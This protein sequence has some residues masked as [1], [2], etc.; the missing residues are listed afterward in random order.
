MGG[1]LCSPSGP[2]PP[3]GVIYLQ[4]RTKPGPFT[5]EDRARAELCAAQIASLADRLLLRNS[6][7]NDGTSAWRERLDAD[8]IIGRSP[9]VAAL[10]EDIALAAP[11]DVSVLIVGETG[12]GKTH[13]ARAIHRN[14]RRNEGPFVEL[15]CATLQ[16][17]LAENEL[18]G[19]VPGAHSTATKA[20]EGKVAAAEGGT[21]FLDEI[22]ELSLPVQ[23]KLLQLLQSKTYFPLG[24][25][26]Q[27]LANVRLIAATNADLEA[28]VAAKTF[29]ADLFY[30]LQVLSLR[31][32][33]LS[34][35]RE[36]VVA[37]AK[38][39]LATVVRRH[40]LP[41]VEL[42]AG[43]CRAIETA[44]WPGNVRQLFHAIESTAIRAAGRGLPRIGPE[45]LF[46][47]SPAV[48]EAHSFQE[49]TRRFQRSLTETNW[50]VT[51]TAQRLDIARSYLYKLMQAHGLRRE[52][53]V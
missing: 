11:L 19:A 47:D 39:H 10:L 49:A 48:E 17:S 21:L 52:G 24:G 29:R 20:T 22:G 27:Q 15:N 38:H 50:N 1:V 12:V 30:R 33:S 28:L 35:R 43:A 8:D 41:M 44:D 45:H 2:A 6:T 14:S 18:F 23:A 5:P 31:V 7:T 4:G 3:L 26:K 51:E 36:D 13:I 53:E 16:E 40:D 46:P 42:S 34:E 25:S 32:P 37:L 9:A